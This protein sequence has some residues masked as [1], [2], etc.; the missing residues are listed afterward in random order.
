M[1]KT[2]LAAALFLTSACATLGMVRF[3]E[4]IVSFKDVKI[5]GLG[6]TGGS[7]EI[8]L[9]VYNPNNFRLDGSRLT[10]QL[11][12]DSLTFGT[13]TYDSRFQVEKGDT[14]EIRLPFNF[15]YAG[16]N[17]AGRQLLQTGSVEYRVLGDVTVNTP[18]GSFTRPY[19]QRGRFNTMSR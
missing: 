19:D 12:V 18:I 13:G 4:P 5:T 2:S 17:A 15:S 6:I 8:V 10:Y 7:M 16:A 1:R 14:S 11:M 3:K 9:D